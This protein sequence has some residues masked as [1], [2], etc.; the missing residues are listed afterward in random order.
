MDVGHKGPLT[1][2]VCRGEARTGPA[3]PVEYDAVLG[4][5][6]PAGYG[7]LPAGLRSSV[8]HVVGPRPGRAVDPLL[9]GRVLVIGDDADL[10]A[11]VV[12][13]LRRDLL[14]VVEIAYAPPAP[15]A[16][17]ALYGLSTGA[18]GVRTAL[19][20]VADRVPLVRHDSGGVLVG[21]AELSPVTGTFYVDARRVPGGARAVR[22]EPDRAAG[23]AVT[24]V[25]RGLFRRTPPPLTGRAVEFGIVPGSGTVITYDGIRHPREV[26]RWVFYAHTEPLLL[27]RDPAGSGAV[28]RNDG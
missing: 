17:T 9:H 18:A 3:T 22:V 8:I 12:R 4:D 20:G 16:I 2:V 15:T 11:V 27:V 28:S 14:G 6:L 25:R 24:M 7:P 5:L 10:N 1:V 23:L 21:R 13:L 19:S 26:N